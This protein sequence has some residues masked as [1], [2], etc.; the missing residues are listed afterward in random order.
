MSGSARRSRVRMRTTAVAP[1]VLFV[2][3]PLSN[4]TV[5]TGH[6]SVELVDCGYP[7]DLRLVE[8][9]IALAGGR[10]QD[11]RRILITHGH[12]DH[13]GSSRLLARTRGVAVATGP[14]E[15]AN[16]RR[17]IEEQV[18]LRELLPVLH[19]PRTI[20][21]VLRAVAAGGLGRVGVPTAV[22]LAGTELALTTGHTLRVVPSPGHTS[23]HTAYLEP[24]AGVLI[25]G[26]ALVTGHPLLDSDGLQL[27]PGF[28]HADPDEAAA[29]GRHLRE[30]PAHWILPGHGA[31]LKVGEAAA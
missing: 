15:A 4:W 12:S 24:S 9:S 6:G 31:P 30:L 11:L 28:F 7:R 22:E 19:R 5:L 1:G 14:V 20:D 13:L 3:G 17:E 2:E 16:V 29:A 18:T 27:L 10:M 21:W 25:A 23:G 26:D 8:R